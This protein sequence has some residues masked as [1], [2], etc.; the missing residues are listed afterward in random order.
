VG[1]PANKRAAVKRKKTV[2]VRFTLYLFSM[3]EKGI[4][5]HSQCPVV[6]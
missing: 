1:S 5:N 3:R 2:K 4:E 6:Y